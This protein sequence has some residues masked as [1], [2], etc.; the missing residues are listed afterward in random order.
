MVSTDGIQ[1]T[2]STADTVF[3]QIP[4]QSELNFENHL[5][6]ICNK[7]SRNINTLGWIANYMFLEKGRI[8]MKT[9]IESQFNYCRLI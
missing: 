7:V 4:N 6:I 8:M 3:T 5:S 1:L 2:S 9:F